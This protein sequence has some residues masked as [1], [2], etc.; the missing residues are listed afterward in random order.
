MGVFCN[1]LT[2]E[3]DNKDQLDSDSFHFLFFGP[4]SF[5]LE[6]LFSSQLKRSK[7]FQYSF[8]I[9]GLSIHA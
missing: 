1:R 3:S 5:K 2:D 6:R 7:K 9:M 8:A 4:Y